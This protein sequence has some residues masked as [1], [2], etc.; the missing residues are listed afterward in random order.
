MSLSAY[1]KKVDKLESLA[2]AM[3]EL[4]TELKSSPPYVDSVATRK[5]A[6]PKVSEGKIISIL[7]DRKKAMRR[8][9]L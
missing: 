7:S 2:D 3:K 4:A 1:M 5:R 6:S 8:K 9:F